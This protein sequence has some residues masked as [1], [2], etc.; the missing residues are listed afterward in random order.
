LLADQIK[1]D[2]A[3]TGGVHT[4][5]DVIKSLMAGAKVTMMASALLQNGIGY[6]STVLTELRI[7]LEQHG[8]SSIQEIQGCLRQGAGGDAAALERA[9][10]ITVLSNNISTVR[11]EPC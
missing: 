5:E 6:L 9:N 1:A 11:S 3:I 10:Y 4:A 8:Y 7:W 2:M